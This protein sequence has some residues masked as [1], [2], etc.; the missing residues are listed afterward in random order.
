MPLGLPGF[1]TVTTFGVGLDSESVLSNQSG[2]KKIYGSQLKAIIISH[3]NVI[4]NQ[5]GTCVRI[6]SV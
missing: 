2:T 5:G 1:T 4:E 3:E 6:E